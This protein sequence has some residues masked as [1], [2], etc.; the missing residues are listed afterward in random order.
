ML[1]SSLFS[2][3]EA[4]LCPSRLKIW[5]KSSALKWPEHTRETL[6][7]SHFACFP[8]TKSTFFFVFSPLLKI[9]IRWRLIPYFEETMLL[10][11]P[12]T[13]LPPGICKRF[14][15]HGVPDLHLFSLESKHCFS[16]SDITSQPD[17][18]SLIPQSW[19]W[20]RQM[21][22]TLKNHRKLTIIAMRKIF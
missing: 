2:H 8:F 20:K 7:G 12:T 4:E 10:Q 15:A 1:I 9:G 5:S 19:T 17:P 22:W 13:H 3:G 6:D 11:P 21:L 16:W 18:F 14:S